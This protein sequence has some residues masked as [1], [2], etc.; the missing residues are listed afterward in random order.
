[1]ERE[2]ERE[3]RATRNVKYILRLLAKLPRRAEL[4]ALL[5]RSH[6]HIISLGTIFIRKN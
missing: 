1:M 4:L 5:R 6:G 2:R 3:R